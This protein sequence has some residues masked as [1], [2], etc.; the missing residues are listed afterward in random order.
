MEIG[1]LVENIDN[2]LNVCVWVYG[3]IVV[4]EN[5]IIYIFYYYNI[6]DRLS[7]NRF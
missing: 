3:L 6:C 1:K 4:F 2:L 7:E 5:F